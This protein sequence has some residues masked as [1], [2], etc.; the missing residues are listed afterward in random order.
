MLQGVGPSLAAEL[1]EAADVDPELLPMELE[2]QEWEDLF[3]QWTR[4]L[5]LITSGR[6]VPASDPVS[7]RLSVLGKG[8]QQE[9]SALKLIDNAFRSHQ[10]ETSSALCICCP[11][12]ISTCKDCMQVYNE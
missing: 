3:A 7:G 9:T 5:S 11:H 12:N 6:F 8:S 1:C 2:K 4:W 10:V